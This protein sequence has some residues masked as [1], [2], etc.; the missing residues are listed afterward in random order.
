MT[1]PLYHLHGMDSSP[2]S[3]K[4]KHLRQF[5]P[6]L[7][8]PALTNDV[9][10]RRTHLERLIQEPAV[11]SGSSLGGL[12]ALDFAILHPHLVKGMV[13]LA[14]AVDFFDRS[15]KTQ[16]ILDYLNALT[17]PPEI[18]TVIIGAV[19][20]DIIPIEAI[21]RLYERSP[22]TRLVELI[23]VDDDHRLHESRSLEI[24]VDA[25]KRVSRNH[26]DEVDLVD[27]VD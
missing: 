9:L 11:L 8:V 3:F 5:F 17:L 23:E 6:D 14:P 10:E 25:V 24:F 1:T 26:V 20:D 13:L 27:R 7:I 15:G 2:D 12:S 21:R 19:Q 4:A 18:P 16:D 22:D